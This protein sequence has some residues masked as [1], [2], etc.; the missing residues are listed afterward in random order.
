MAQVIA[1]I[2]FFL[3]AGIANM[4]PV[5]FRFIPCNYP[6]DANKKF[7]GKPLLGANKTWRGLILGILSA[8]VFVWIQKLLYQPM[9][10]YSLVD[11]S[12]VNVWL[13]GLMLGFGALFGDLVASFSKR[14]LKISPG[15]PWTPFDQLDWVVGA[16]IF[17]TPFI[18]LSLKKTL[19]VIFI[20]LILHPIVNL[21]GFLLRLKKKKY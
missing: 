14:Q 1:L 13:L 3:P 4:T 18:T 16:I 17:S 9:Q 19:V 10:A 8:I 21:G 2:W 20:A 15:Q 7:R 6:L 5:I 11:Y 12:T